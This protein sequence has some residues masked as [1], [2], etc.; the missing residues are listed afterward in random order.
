[1]TKA[2]GMF[3]DLSSVKAHGLVAVLRRQKLKALKGKVFVEFC[4]A[5]DSQL[6]RVCKKLGIRYLG[7]SLDWVDLRDSQQMD[8]IVE[9][10]RFQTDEQGFELHLFGSLPCTVWS[11]LQQLNLFKLSDDFK[12]DLE[13]RRRETLTSVDNF[14]CLGHIAQRSGGSVS[15]E[16]PKGCSSWHQPTVLQMMVTFDMFSSYPTGCSFKLCIKDAIL[17]NLGEL[18]QPVSGLP[19]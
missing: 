12:H 2:Q 16:W 1:M 5:A 9:W 6:K 7:L 19:P 4:C 11:S 17:C 13:L 3:Q 18:S 8:Q 10:A 14:V 15:F